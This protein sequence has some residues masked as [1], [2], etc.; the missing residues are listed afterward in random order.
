MVAIL[1]DSDSADDK[2][3]DAKMQ[4]D[5]PEKTVEQLKNGEID[6]SLYSRQL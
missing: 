3:Q 1:E 5:N 6:E 4:L 2:F